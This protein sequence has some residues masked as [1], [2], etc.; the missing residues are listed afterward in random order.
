MILNNKRTELLGAGLQT[1]VYAAF[2]G[3]SPPQSGFSL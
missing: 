1:A 3:I 2:G